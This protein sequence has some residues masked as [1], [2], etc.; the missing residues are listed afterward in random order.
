MKLNLR[1]IFYL[2]E[3]SLI[4]GPQGF[5]RIQLIGFIGIHIDLFAYMVLLLAVILADETIL[6]DEAENERFDLQTAKTDFTIGDDEASLYDV[7]DSD[8]CFQLLVDDL[9]M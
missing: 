4:I 3:E 5:I 1:N 9:D 2:I 6:A 8:F 7:A